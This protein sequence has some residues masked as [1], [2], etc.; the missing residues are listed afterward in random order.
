LG[1]TL[2]ITPQWTDVQL[3]AAQRE[4]LLELGPDLVPGALPVRGD[5]P[6]GRELLA[7]EQAKVTLVLPTSI[8][9]ALESYVTTAAAGGGLYPSS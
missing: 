6:V 5:A 7:V 1:T 3:Q 8:A 2:E 4:E 9:G